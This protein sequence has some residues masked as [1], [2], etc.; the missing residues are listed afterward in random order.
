[1]LFDEI[2]SGGMATVRF[3]RLIGEG[4]FSRTVAVKC[5]HAHFAK[6]EEFAAMFLD[7]A[8][9][10]ARIQHLNVVGTVD[11]VAREGE[12]YLVM[13][14]VHGESLSKLVRESRRRRTRIP[15]KIVSA[16]IIGALEGLH[17]AHIAKSELGVPLGIV[18]RDVSPQNVMVGVDGIARVLDFGI[19]KAAGRL[20]T[21]RDG[22]IKGKLA[23]IA[24]E[25]LKAEDVDRRTDIYST[26]VM[27]WEALTGKRLFKADD[28]VGLF[29]MVLQGATLPP[30]ALV[31]DLPKVLDEVTMRGLARDPADRY[32]TARDMAVALE[33]A[34]GYAS[35]REVGAWVE[36]LASE[37]LAVRAEKIAELE[38]ISS[39]SI[40]AMMVGGKP[41]ADLGNLTSP[42]IN[43]GIAAA[44]IADRP[45]PID[46]VE[47]QVSSA[48]QLP[49]PRLPPKPRTTT[50]GAADIVSF[51]APTDASS[52][53]QNS[54]ELA[55][56][57]RVPFE[58]SDGALFDPSQ[59]DLLQENEVRGPMTSEPSASSLSNIGSLALDGLNN[60]VGRR[61]SQWR[62]IWKIGA[63]A[64]FGS[65]AIVGI[66][67]L[68]ASIL[69]DREPTLATDDLEAGTITAVGFVD[70]EVTIIATSSE[71]ETSTKDASTEEQDTTDARD[72]SDQDSHA[73]PIVKAEPS[74]HQP[75]SSATSRPSRPTRP[76]QPAPAVSQQPSAGVIQQPPATKPKADCNPPYTIDSRGVRVPKPHCL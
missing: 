48:R 21:T 73:M 24:P 49:P 17:A 57:E 11:V 44:A 33:Q 67:M 15:V 72:A 62:M 42:A 37:T 40:K 29:G 14:Y 19:A 47:S 36:N 68:V 76:N 53:W 9:L 58:G 5:L 16:I 22:Q 31:P 28:E 23:Y 50:S 3:G 70:P 69:K 60:D 27:L 56:P 13:D 2:A 20:Q 66:V 1:M 52:G 35:A 64:L 12:L 18:H 26:S 7:E 75:T 46:E 10:A 61:R 71:Y 59:F 54:E 34:V 41:T 32:D 65:I 63:V 45:T 30:S 43:L 6:D 51:V 8:R 25:Q 39:T 38:S 74:A 55:A 4:G